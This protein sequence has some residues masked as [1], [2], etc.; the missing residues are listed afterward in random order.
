MNEDMQRLCNAVLVACGQDTIE[1][2]GHEAEVIVRAVLDTLKDPTSRTLHAAG[3]YKPD[4]ERWI[5]ADLAA[6]IDRILAEPGTV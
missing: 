5:R 3:Y 2:S 6:V 1:I 4:Q